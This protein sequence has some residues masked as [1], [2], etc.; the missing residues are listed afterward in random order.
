MWVDYGL[1]TFAF[2]ICLTVNIPMN[3]FFNISPKVNYFVDPQKWNQRLG[4]TMALRFAEGCARITE[5]VDFEE[6]QQ[7]R[8]PRLKNLISHAYQNVPA[9]RDHYIKHGVKLLDIQSEVDLALL[10][11]IKKT[12]LKEYA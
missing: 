7:M 12:D 4:E 2:V 9:Y 11:S 1:G 8:W 5:Y 3:F 6:I 10:P